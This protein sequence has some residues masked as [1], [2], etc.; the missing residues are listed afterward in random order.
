MEYNSSRELLVIPEYGRHVQ[1]MV[2]HARTIENPEER[3]VFV[4]QVVK[5]IMQ[6]HPQNKNLD[7]YRDKMWKHVFRIAEYDLD[8]MPP[9]GDVPTEEDRKKRP[10]Q[11]EYPVKGTKYKH[12]GHNVL[13]LIAKAKEMEPGPKK[14]RLCSSD[15]LLYEI[16]L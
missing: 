10:K 4:E 13:T 5:L 14:K 11:V 2:R 9:N 16:G 6:M 3:Q 12:Y 7:D 15:W 8:V 1:G